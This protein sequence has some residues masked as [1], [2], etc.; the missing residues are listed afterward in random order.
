MDHGFIEIRDKATIKRLA[1]II[2]DGDNQQANRAFDDL[3]DTHGLSLGGDLWNAAERL[4]DEWSEAEN[5]G[6]R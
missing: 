4:V 1:G 5:G 3:M 6:A 2:R